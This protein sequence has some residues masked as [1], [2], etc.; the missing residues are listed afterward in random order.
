MKRKPPV[1]ASSVPSHLALDGQLCFAL[2][3]ASLGLNKAYRKLLL[4]LG[5]TYPQYLVM[6][7]LWESDGLTVSGVGEKLF[8]NSTTLT[9]LLKRLEKAGLLKR[10]RSAADERSVIV[11]L[12]EKGRRLKRPAL[13]VPSC[14][15]AAMAMPL[16]QLHALKEQL[17]ELRA[18]LFRFA[19]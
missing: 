19:A 14:A 16:A 4:P 7:V 2:Y 5:L 15:A 11:S 18:N 3:S 12:T 8:L 6:L 9:P 1:A 13:E 17:S 10:V